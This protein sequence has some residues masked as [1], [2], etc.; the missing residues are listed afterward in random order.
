MAQDG[1]RL[2]IP[3]EFEVGDII[4]VKVDMLETPFNDMQLSLAGQV[5]PPS[6]PARRHLKFQPTPSCRSFQVHTS[7]CVAM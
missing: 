5:P 3:K 7:V 2:G 1:T 4:H 6:P